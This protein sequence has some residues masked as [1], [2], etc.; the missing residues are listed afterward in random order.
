MLLATTAIDG[1]AVEEDV[2]M[3]LGAFPIAGWAVVEVCSMAIA[4]F[5][6][7]GCEARET[8][9]LAAI[10]TREW[11]VVEDRSMAL[12]AVPT[13]GCTMVK[14]HAMVYAAV[15]IAGRAGVRVRSIV[16][17]V[18]PIPAWVVSVVLVAIRVLLWESF[19]A[20]YSDFVVVPHLGRG[21]ASA[22]P[23]VLAAAPTLGRASVGAVSTVGWA[24]IAALWMVIR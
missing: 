13:D 23:L 17:V 3:V 24:L 19:E 11:A 8:Q 14:S 22:L 10:P 1:K 20:L 6:I 15:R 7:H 5:L 2:E 9:V 4:E 12:D 16:H 21:M 18:A